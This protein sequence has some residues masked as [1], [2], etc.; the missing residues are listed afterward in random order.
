M[1]QRTERIGDLIR[2]ELSEL[3]R[4]EMNDPRVQLASIS[5]VAVSP[6]LRQARVGV[7]VLG[8]ET[9][10][11][12]AVRALERAKGFL[13][14][15][16]AHRLSLRVTPELHFELDRGAEHSRQIEDLLTRAREGED[17]GS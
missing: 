10:R 15:S 12:D 4:R 17:D 9:Q 2:G 7:S 14:H 6:D 16:L 1:S 8:S 13:R 5:R 3:L 11:D